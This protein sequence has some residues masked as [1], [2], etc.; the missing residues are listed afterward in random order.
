MVWISSLYLVKVINLTIFFWIKN[1][2]LSLAWYELKLTKRYWNRLIMDTPRQIML[3][4][5]SDFCL[6]LIFNLLRSIKLTMKLINSNPSFFMHACVPMRVASATWHDVF[7]SLVLLPE[8]TLT[9]IL[10][11]TILESTV[12][13]ICYMRIINNVRFLF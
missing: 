3:C 4:L 10:L 2:G 6:F 12:V 5:S 11:T 7:G 1:N 13:L 9:D 8:T